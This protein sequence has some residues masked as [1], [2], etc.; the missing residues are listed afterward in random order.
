[1]KY[2]FLSFASA[3][4]ELAHRAVE[5]L[6]RAGVPCW[7]ADRDITM[8]SSYPAAITAA[9]KGSGAFL[10]LLTDASNGSPHV[11][12]EVEL[13]FTARRPIL[14]VCIAGVRPSSDLQYFLSTSQWLD[15]GRT[16]DQEDL[17]KIEP[18]LRQMIE[19]GRFSGD[20]NGG[21]RQWLRYAV[22]AA[23]VVAVSA[24]GINWLRQR[25]APTP[26][27]ASRASAPSPSAPAS[28]P[29][30]TT[31]TSTAPEAA[32]PT[33]PATTAASRSTAPTVKVNPRDGQSY[34]WIAPGRFVMGCSSGDPA[35]DDDEKPAHAVEI[36]RGYWLASTEVTTAQFRKTSAASSAPNG[37]AGNVPVT[38]VDWSEAKAY[39]ARVGGRLPTEAEWEYAARAG[40]QTRYYGN[41]NAIAWFDDNSDGR[42]HP[43]GGKTPNAFGLHDMLGNVS[44]WVLDRYYNTYDDASDP[45]SPDQPLA[46]N[47]SGVARGGSWISE[48]AGARVSRRLSM[49]PDAQE[50][51]IGFR[52]AAN[53]L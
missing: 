3:D 41:L 16:F 5:S 27:A 31:T 36:T 52:C 35:C 34:V 32:T 14:P 9:I 15:A 8:G 49:P 53:R 21:S 17:A 40:E 30:P 24:A 10:L 47:A 4:V 20:L 37:A 12:R 19:R 38:R 18:V 44:E 25:P 13:A 1:M 6:E 26:A 48:A 28:A 45:L 51:H 29:P 23:L 2:A 43:V 33:A 50:P 42:P 46:G 39:C 22:A 11:L 7:I